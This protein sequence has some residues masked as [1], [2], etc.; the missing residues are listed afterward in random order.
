MPHGQ[1]HDDGDPGYMHGER[2]GLIKPGVH[3]NEEFTPS[4][5]SDDDLL[6]FNNGPLGGKPHYSKGLTVI[7]EKVETRDNHFYAQ[8]RYKL[9]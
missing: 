2:I 9:P 8:V 1:V 4:S 5:E 7:Y 3:D 6:P